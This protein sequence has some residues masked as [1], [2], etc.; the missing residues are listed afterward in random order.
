MKIWSILG[1]GMMISGGSVMVTAPFFE[2][3]SN[4]IVGGFVLIAGLAIYIACSITNLGL[5]SSGAEK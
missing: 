1:I 5:E 2:S 4:V 3:I